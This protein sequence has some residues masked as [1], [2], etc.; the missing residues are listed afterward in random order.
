MKSGGKAQSLPRKK[1]FWEAR[2]FDHW[3]SHVGSRKTDAS[4]IS[5]YFMRLSHNSLFTIDSDLNFGVCVFLINVDGQVVQVFNQFFQIF[6][7]DLR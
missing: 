1:H 4:A 7:L 3:I 6:R 2:S 5:G